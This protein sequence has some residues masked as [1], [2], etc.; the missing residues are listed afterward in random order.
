MLILVFVFAYNR[1]EIRILWNGKFYDPE[2]M[3]HDEEE[4]DNYTY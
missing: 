4:D 2:F 3:N 1:K